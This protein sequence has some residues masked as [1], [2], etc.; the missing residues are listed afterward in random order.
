MQSGYSREVCGNDA[1]L[2]GAQN[3]QQ[4]GQNTEASWPRLRE[5]KEARTRPALSGLLCVLCP[6]SLQ[7]RSAVG[8]PV[9]MPPRDPELRNSKTMVR[10]PQLV[11]RQS[12]NLPQ[13]YMTAELLS[14]PLHSVRSGLLWGGRDIA[15][16]AFGQRILQSSRLAWWQLLPLE[17][18]RMAVPTPWESGQQSSAGC[19]LSRARRLRLCSSLG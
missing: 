13:V 9:S 2:K 4:P 17:H 6:L 19:P 16:R 3:L 18:S 15:T 11:K 7:Q 8:I 5:D 14:P 10:V 12:K 1:V